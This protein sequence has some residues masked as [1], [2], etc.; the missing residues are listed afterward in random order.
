MAKLSKTQFRVNGLARGARLDR[1]L[2]DQYPLWGRQ[3]V[4]RLISAGQVKLNRQAVWIASWEVNNGDQIE[5]FDPPQNKITPPLQWQDAWLLSDEGDMIVV[6]KPAGLLSEPPRFSTAPNLLGIAR[7]RFGEVILFHRLDRDTSGVVLLTRPGPI[8]KYLDEAF[9]TRTIHKQYLAVVAKPHKL[10]AAGE[11]NARIGPHPHRRDQMT[12]VQRG[13][14]GAFT[15]FQ[16]EEATSNKQLVRLWPET[17]RTHQLR[18]HLAHLG[19]PILGDRL[20]SKTAPRDGERLCLHAQQIE[21]P[22]EEHFPARTFSAPIPK[23][24]WP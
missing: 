4:Q 3:A 9:K 15:R 1:V 8:N 18:V 23:G 24:F 5:I 11:I 12:V 20:Y 22:E 16:L 7:E 6:N 21:L 10:P 13:G 2:R 17:G 14:Q 19:S